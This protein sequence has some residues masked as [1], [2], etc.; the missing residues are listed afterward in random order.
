M[1]GPR[2]RGATGSVGAV[3]SHGRALRSPSAGG[4]NDG[5][6]S[7]GAGGRVPDARELWEQH[8][9]ALTVRALEEIGQ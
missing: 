9:L 8:G 2:P 6:S 5:Q 7:M 4:R 3:Q 1:S